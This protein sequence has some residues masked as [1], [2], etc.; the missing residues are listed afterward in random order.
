MKKILSIFTLL[1]VANLAIGQTVIHGSDMI[2]GELKEGYYLLLKVDE[3]ILNSEWREYLNPYGRI[4]EVEK[5]RYSLVK[6]NNRKYGRNC[7]KF[8]R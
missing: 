7:E 4:S 2:D 8:F 6:F 1:F 3:K 5:N